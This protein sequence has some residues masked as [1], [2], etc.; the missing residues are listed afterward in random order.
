MWKNVMV[1]DTFGGGGSSGSSV[2]LFFSWFVDYYSDV[3]LRFAEG[4]SS[5]NS[6]VRVLNV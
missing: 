5:D 6:T 3:F 2:L 1:L 4:F